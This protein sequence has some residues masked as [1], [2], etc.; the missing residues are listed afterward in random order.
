MKRS[1]N[2]ILVLAGLLSSGIASRADTLSFGLDTAYTGTPPEGSAPWITATIEDLVP[3]SVRLTL[4]NQNLSEQEYVS[5]WL[6]NL[7]PDLAASDLD[8]GN[9]VQTGS[10]AL[11]A[12]QTAASKTKAGGNVQFSLA[13]DFATAQ[14]KR[15]GAG[16]KLVYEITG[17]PGL[18]A[19][20][21]AFTA[22]NG[23]YGPFG[24]AAHVQ[25]ID[26]ANF[27][28]AISDFDTQSGWIASDLTVT[29][30]PA[31]WMILPSFLGLAFL[32]RKRRH[33]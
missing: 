17:I 18:T 22:Q 6:F 21:F 12:V 3:G 27:Q 15:F 26:P 23:S 20:D 24:A 13:L 32:A 2:I 30:E 4:D 16:E 31:A 1:L 29:P 33:N 5:K 8:F 11:P 25:S 9:P 14:A 10:F 28:N 19:A 7:N